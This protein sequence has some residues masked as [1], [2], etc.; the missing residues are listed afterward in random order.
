MTLKEKLRKKNVYVFLG[1]GCCSVCGGVCQ[2]SEKTRKN[3]ET[4]N[5][6]NETTLFLESPINNIWDI[7]NKFNLLSTVQPNSKI[8]Y[9]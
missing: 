2:Q 1:G 4:E 7:L 9:K 5:P 8:I 3:R 6:I